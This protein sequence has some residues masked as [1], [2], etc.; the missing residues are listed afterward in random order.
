MKQSI[1]DNTFVRITMSSPVDRDA[2]I[3]KIIARF[4]EIKHKP[5]LNF[6][7]RYKTRDI[8]RNF[9][10]D[11]GI[12][13][14]KKLLSNEYKAATLFTTRNDVLFIR[15]ASR[16][17]IKT[18]PPTF[19]TVPERKHDKS[20]FRHL[21]NAS[22]NYLFSLG[23]ADNCGKILPSG[24]DKYRQIHHFIEILKSELEQFKF[25]GVLKVADMGSG[26]GYMTFALYDYLSNTLKIPTEM[27]GTEIREELVDLCNSIAEQQNFERLKFVCSDIQSH[28]IAEVD[29]LVAL[30]ACD[31]A[32]DLAIHKGIL[33]GAVMI[34]TAPCCH[35]QIRREMETYTK[36]S[37]LEFIIRHGIFLERQAELITDSMRALIL[38]YFGYKVK[39]IE[40][41]ADAHTHK[42][43]MIIATKKTTEHIDRSAIREKISS[44]KKRFGIRYHELEK[45]SGLKI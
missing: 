33:A 41:I 20:K 19:T 17:Q 34:V 9:G 16:I 10:N 11:E 40:F 38:E 26:K 30:H 22:G 36:N 12:S 31:T 7:Y 24:Q 21:Q 2:E 32:T 23:L 14:I 27:T 5:A 43:V 4:I 42:N 39:I 8:T 37:G 29:I 18:I 25:H 3:V 15:K 45:I 6:I 13:V 35:K 28:G 44:V 1:A